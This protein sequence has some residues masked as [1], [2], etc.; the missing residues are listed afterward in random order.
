MIRALTYA[1][2][3]FLAITHIAVVGK[4]SQHENV[5][6]MN[7]DQDELFVLPSAILKIAS[8][9]Y[10]GIVSDYLFIK[11]IV[12]I[13]GSVQKGSSQKFNINESQWCAF[14]NMMQISTDLDPYF[15]DP[16]YI[17]NAFLT[18]D[19]GMTREANSLLEKGSRYRNWD[20]SL[21]FFSGFNYFFFLNEN[22]KASEWLMEAS[23]RP[24]AS[25]TIAS[26]ASKIAFKASKTENSISF[27]E[28]MIKQTEDESMK[29]MFAGRVEAYKAILDLEKAV[30]AYQR[31][32]GKKPS[33][34][35]RL[36][37]NKIILEVPKEPYGGKFYI[38][39][40]GNVRTTSE[41]QLMPFQK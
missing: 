29:K 3:A 40:G 17:A 2:L 36:L 16:Y 12:Y 9:D 33:T 26:L 15:Q 7:E 20:W 21:P 13:G 4:L 28:E 10:K 24:G 11:G 39:S 23:R 34:L 6:P 27:L 5:F 30:D 41:N 22:D 1:L 32:F 18:W 8:F 19:A 37:K 14:Y 31:K 35:E 25:P 38:D